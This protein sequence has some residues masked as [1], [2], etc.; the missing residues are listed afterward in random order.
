M[1]EQGQCS[2]WNNLAVDMQSP[3]VLGVVLHHKPSVSS[4]SVPRAV[5]VLP[6]PVVTC[7][8]FPAELIKAPG[9]GG[10]MKE[11]SII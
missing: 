5:I 11:I 10:K 8:N 6:A 9:R 3:Q 7:V 1:K 4:C 2:T